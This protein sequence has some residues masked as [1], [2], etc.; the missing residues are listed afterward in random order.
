MRAAPHISGALAG[1]AIALAAAASALAAPVQ[2]TGQANRE[3]LKGAAQAPLRDLNV[4]RTEIPDVLL[5]AKA[6]PYGRPVSTKCAVLASE[7]DLLNDA[8]G[9]DLDAPPPEEQADI[10]GKGRGTVLG[11]VAGA[12]SGAIPFHGV[13]R[14][15]SG[16][17]EHDNFVQASITAGNVRRAYLKGLGEA[18]G[19]L[20]PATPS[21][22]KAGTPVLEAGKP[23]YPIR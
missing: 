12:A 7:I 1:L 10:K 16:A 23:R 3:S 17:E 8:L 5:Q 15:L 18:K 13:V 9:P 22:V 21:H 14:K 6:D 11:A 2:T 19:C 20:P 4:V